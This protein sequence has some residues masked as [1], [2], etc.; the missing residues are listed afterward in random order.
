MCPQ[1]VRPI[2]LGAPPLAGTWR[3]F[4]T[5]HNLK[6]GPT[7]ARSYPSSVGRSRQSVPW[8]GVS[9]RELSLVGESQQSAPS[10]TAKPLPKPLC[11]TEAD[12][13]SVVLNSK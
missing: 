13:F 9:K 10:C 12:I 4:A 3:A 1:V 8:K 11:L 5:D 7:E 2:P 6:Y